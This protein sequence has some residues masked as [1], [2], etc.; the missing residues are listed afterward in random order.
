MSYYKMKVTIVT[1][2]WV[3]MQFRMKR[4]EKKLDNSN[5]INKIT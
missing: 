4:V 2:G 1:S 3:K 5:L